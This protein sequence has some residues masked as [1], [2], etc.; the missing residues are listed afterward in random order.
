MAIFGFGIGGLIV[1][2]AGLTAAEYCPRE[3]VG[4]VKGLIGLFSYIAASIQEYVSG[5]MIKSTGRGENAQYDFD[6][7][8]TFWIAAGVLSLVLALSVK[9]TVGAPPGQKPAESIPRPERDATVG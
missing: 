5:V 6:E 3:A 2:L 1:F 9:F 4:A 8:I 7:A